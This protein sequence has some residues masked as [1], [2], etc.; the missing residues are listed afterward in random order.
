MFI[1][2]VTKSIIY[3]LEGGWSQMRYKVNKLMFINLKP[4]LQFAS[5]P[6]AIKCRNV[7]KLFLK[8]NP[9]T[10]MISL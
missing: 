9:S 5:K 3:V 6:N 2:L 4:K 7:I 1:F 10:N 8:K